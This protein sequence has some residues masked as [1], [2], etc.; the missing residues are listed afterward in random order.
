[1]AKLIIFN[2][3]F[4]VLSQFTDNSGKKTLAD[5]INVKAV[6]PAGRL[7]FDSEGLL[8]LTDDGLL[9][10]K[11]SDPKYKLSKTYWVQVEGNA[12]Q[13]Q[14]DEL[15]AGV[16]LKDG[17][18]TALSCKLIPEPVLWDRVPPIRVRKLIPDSWMEIVINEGRNRQIRRMTA[19]VNLPTL[20]LVRAKVGDWT[21]D[22]LN[23]G[24]YSVDDTVT[25][26]SLSRLNAQSN[27]R[28]NTLK[29]PQ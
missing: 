25:S 20:R 27:T 16:S 2:K 19:A 21:F 14:C 24:E 18:A 8:L 3:P 28:L 26:A 23:P 7:D 17:M 13:A 1:M 5:Y 9:Q 4:Q 11:I 22:G 10:A 12:T 6:Y 15:L 29:Q